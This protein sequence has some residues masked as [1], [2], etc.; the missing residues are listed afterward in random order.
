VCARVRVTIGRDHRPGSRSRE[1]RYIT[2]S[3][4][5]RGDLHKIEFTVRE[6]TL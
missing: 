6:L 4:V 1:R 5:R 2:A 3:Q